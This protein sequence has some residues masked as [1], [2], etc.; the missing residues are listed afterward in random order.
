M[1]KFIMNKLI[2]AAFVAATTDQESSEDY[3]V[4]H[5]RYLYRP[6]HY[7]RRL[8]Y[9]RY[10][11]QKS[12][13]SQLRWR[14][15]LRHLW[16]NRR[17]IGRIGRYAWRNRHRFLRRRRYLPAKSEDSQLS[18]LSFGSAAWRN[19]RLIARIGLA[20]WRRRHQAYLPAQSEKT[21]LSFLGAGFVV[22][23]LAW[24]HRRAL[25]NRT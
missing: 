9:R 23:S 12:E 6:Y 7:A 14:R 20:A 4:I 21:Q 10:L 16:R 19:R 5:R 1:G 11:P 8:V 3:L 15:S 18:L 24:K 17:L 22:G 13:E 25:M 2:L